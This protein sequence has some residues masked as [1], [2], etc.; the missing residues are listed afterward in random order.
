MHW[1]ARASARSVKPWLSPPSLKRGCRCVASEDW[2]LL[3][4]GSSFGL[5]FSLDLELPQ[6][7]LRPD[8]RAS[9]QLRPGDYR[10]SSACEPKTAALQPLPLGRCCA[11][12]MLSGHSEADGGASARQ[13]TA[14]GRAQKTETQPGLFTHRCR[15]R[16]RRI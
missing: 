16:L 6:S 3:G 7:T 10:Q 15:G 11:D 5:G 4:A 12:R 1:Q 2:S 14:C 13:P 9:R 8:E